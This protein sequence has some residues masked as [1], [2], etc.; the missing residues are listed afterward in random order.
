MLRRRRKAFAAAAALGLFVVVILAQSM[1]LRERRRRLLATTED[2]ERSLIRAYVGH[3]APPTQEREWLRQ[4]RSIQE[5]QRRKRRMGVCV[6]G[7]MGR[8]ELESKRRNFLRV[9]RPFYEIT[10]V[11]VA[12][13]AK[14]VYFANAGTDPGLRS[15]DW[16]RDTI[17]DFLGDD[18]DELLVDDEPQEKFPMIVS[19]YFEGAKEEKRTT[20]LLRIQSHVRQWLGLRRCD[21][22]FSGSFD[23]FV[24]LRDDSFVAAPFPVQNLDYDNAVIVPH[25]LGWNGYNDKVAV[26]DARYGDAFFAGPASDYYLNYTLLNLTKGYHN[27]ES[28]LKASLARRHVPVRFA[29]VDDVPVFT[30]R[31]EA[32]DASCFVYSK[33]KLGDEP[34]C[35]PSSCALRRRIHCQA[36]AH[37]FE[38][39]LSDL[40][41]PGDAASNV[42]TVDSSNFEVTA[43]SSSSGRVSHSRRPEDQPTCV[44]ECEG[45][46][47]PASL[48]PRKRHRKYPPP[49]ASSRGDREKNKCP[50]SSSSS[51]STQQPYHHRSR[52]S[53]ERESPDGGCAVTARRNAPL[54]S[55]I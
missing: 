24:K 15:I 11:L 53:D 48:E 16:T 47:D 51:S 30:T 23:V 55:E 7:Q 13:K 21:Q 52:A 3:R 45:K 37:G 17:K 4:R 41:F 6:V 49:A 19:D 29:H 50:P 2:S 20:T 28:V 35:F 12:A 33:Y 32:H 9:N 14:D 5:E 8:L 44:A 27:P 10:L 22:H 18:V 26:L 54:F 39:S 36:C 25:C 1:T 31:S 42:S 40:F 34:M 38:T 46:T 43:R